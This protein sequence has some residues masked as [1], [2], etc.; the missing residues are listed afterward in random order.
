MAHE[1]LYLVTLISTKLPCQQQLWVNLSD[2]FQMLKPQLVPKAAL[3][4]TSF[5]TKITIE[6]NLPKQSL[7]LKHG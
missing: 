2:A 4:K 7:T 5:I 6:D 1:V 3:T